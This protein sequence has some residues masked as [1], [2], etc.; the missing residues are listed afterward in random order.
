MTNN[1]IGRSQSKHRL[2]KRELTCHS[3]HLSPPQQ[4]C[5]PPSRPARPRTSAIVPNSQGAG[6]GA[7]TAWLWTAGTPCTACRWS[8]LAC[9]ST[10][11]RVCLSACLPVRLS[12]CL[13][14]FFSLI[15]GRFLSVSVSLPLSFSLSVC[16]SLLSLCLLVVCFNNSDKNS[17]LL[18]QEE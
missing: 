9:A 14:R 12:V 1:S 8:T 17:R 18:C 11:V 5:S 16:L 2:F 10:P 3:V 15:L 13:V 6:P 7:P 4:V